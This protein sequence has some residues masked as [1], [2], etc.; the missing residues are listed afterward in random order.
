M[1]IRYYYYAPNIVYTCMHTSSFLF[2]FLLSSFLYDEIEGQEK[3]YNKRVLIRS[4]ILP[5]CSRNSTKL[6]TWPCLLTP[7]DRIAKR[8]RMNA[9]GIR[10]RARFYSYQ[11]DL[12]VRTESPVYADAKSQKK[13]RRRRR[14]RSSPTTTHLSDGHAIFGMCFAYA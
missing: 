4:R 10:S 13:R 11:H 6:R 2:S 1:L 9:H 5:T 12:R 8:Q 14:W 3:S 7:H